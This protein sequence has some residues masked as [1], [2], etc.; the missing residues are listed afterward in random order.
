MISILIHKSPLF[1]TNKLSPPLRQSTDKSL[2]NNARK[3]NI[4]TLWGHPKKNSN[5]TS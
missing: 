3:S 5:N 4:Q 1:L 2:K